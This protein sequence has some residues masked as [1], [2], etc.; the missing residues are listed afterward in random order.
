[1]PRRAPPVAAPSSC[2]LCGGRL[3]LG[4]AHECPRPKT[5][6]GVDLKW[7]IG[8][9]LQFLVL[10]GTMLWK[11]AVLVSELEALKRQVSE[12][13]ERLKGVEQYFKKPLPRE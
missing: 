7:A 3:L 13:N 11:G 5:T 6:R 4:V 9:I 8:F 12:Q 2:S 10:L 1:M